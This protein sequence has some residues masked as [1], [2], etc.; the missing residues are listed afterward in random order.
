MVNVICAVGNKDI[1]KYLQS[2][3]SMNCLTVIKKR[4]N[5]LNRIFDFKPNVVIISKSLPGKGSIE[6]ILL[7]IR[8]NFPDVKIVVLYGDQDNESRTFLD[9]LVRN[10]I[11][12]FVIGAVDEKSLDDAILTNRTYDDVS[13]YVIEINADNESL[14]ELEVQELKEQAAAVFRAP[15]EPI[16]I[17]TQYVKE[18]IGTYRIAITSFFERAGCT[19]TA[20]TL[21]KWFA[22]HGLDVGVI[23]SVNIYG[24]IKDYYNLEDVSMFNIKFYCAG[25][26]EAAVANNKIIIEDIGKVDFDFKISADKILTVN[27]I[28]IWEQDRIL[29]FVSQKSSLAA[30]LNWLIYPATSEYTQMARNMNS[31]GCD[32]YKKAYTPDWFVDCKEDNDVFQRIFGD[33]ILICTKTNKRK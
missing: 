17:K 28:G 31:I 10:G 18:Y 12:D 1:E 7:Q 16:Q 24:A 9:M 29:D 20:L 4:E 13:E 14:K 23:V 6:K 2:H 33:F 8:T 22:A 3:R 5:I 27:P 25:S 26:Q 32:I 30:T 21:G 15:P 19:H 11:Y